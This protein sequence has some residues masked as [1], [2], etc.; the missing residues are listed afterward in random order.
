MIKPIEEINHT[1]IREEL[2]N[3]RTFIESNIEL[4]IDA[5]PHMECTVPIEKAKEITYK[6]DCL[7]NSALVI[8]LKEIYKEAAEHLL[9]LK[10]I[11]DTLK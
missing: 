6:I 1:N 8:E 10:E 5:A 4:I 11:R 3:V 2:H 9:V 7:T